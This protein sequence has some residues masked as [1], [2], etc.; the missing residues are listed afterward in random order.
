MRS[1][2]I[3]GVGLGAAFVAGAA[4]GPFGVAGAGHA[5]QVLTADLDGRSEVV[6]GAQ[7]DRIVGDPDG[8][9]EV[10]VFGIDDDATTLC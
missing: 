5:N 3:A 9:G 6:N 1:K 2:L 7:D 8:R 10:H 4:F